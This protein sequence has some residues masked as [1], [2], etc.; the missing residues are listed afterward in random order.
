MR[1]YDFT[2]VLR[3]DLELTDEIADALF[4]AGCDDGTPGRSCGA[5][6]IDFHREAATLEQAIRSAMS[7][8]NGAGFQ[9][10][11]VEMQAEALTA[12]A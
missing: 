8:V 1:K 12:S 9:V 5:F 7:D 10:T 2:L 3:E 11:R 4:A 6:V